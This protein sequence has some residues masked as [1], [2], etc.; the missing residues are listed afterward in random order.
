MKLRL[1]IWT[2][3]GIVV[4]AFGIFILLAG[5]AGQSKRVTLN[6]LK[7]QLTRT[8]QAVNDLTA[9]LAQAKAVPLPP[10]QSELLGKAEE[11]LN[12]ARELLQE[13]KGSNERALV[14]KTLREIHQLIRQCR[15][16]IREAKKPNV[17]GGKG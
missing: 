17:S 2:V 7:R 1:V 13:A 14:E 15:R 5:K 9:K 4:V 3:V 8:E 12:R 11:N 10:P 16:F 6:D